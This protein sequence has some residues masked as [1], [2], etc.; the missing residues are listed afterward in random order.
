[1]RGQL[2]RFSGVVA[3]LLGV[4]AAGARAASPPPPLRVAL[5]GNPNTVPEWTDEQVQAL[6]DAGFTAVQLNVAWGSRPQGEPLNLRDVVGL[7]GQPLDPVV[8]KRQSE[9]RSGSTW[10]RSTGC[11]R[12]STSARPT[13]G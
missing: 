9:L 4:A 7:A 13:C 6:K 8:A 10:R 3:L 12:S 5:L 11:E 1:M 2:A